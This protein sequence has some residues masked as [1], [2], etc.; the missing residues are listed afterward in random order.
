MCVGIMFGIAS[1]FSWIYF[2]L[3][4]VVKTFMAVKDEHGFSDAVIAVFYVTCHIIK[5]GCCAIAA[6]IWGWCK[7]L[8]KLHKEKKQDLVR[9]R[10]GAE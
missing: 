8:I 4:K 7:Y 2:E 5:G 9:N 10:K 3:R 1:L 6:K